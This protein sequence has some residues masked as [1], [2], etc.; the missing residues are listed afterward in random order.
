MTARTRKPVGDSE[1]ASQN[2]IGGGGMS[3]WRINGT[4]T[5]E[6]SMHV[7]GC[8]LRRFSCLTGG[9]EI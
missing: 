7:L 4:V 9:I 1:F 2:Q 8:A 6:R 5:F 3:I